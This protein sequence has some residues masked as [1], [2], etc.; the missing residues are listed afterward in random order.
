M[1]NCIQSYKLLSYPSL[2]YSDLLFQPIYFLDTKQVS[3]PPKSIV[4]PPS[5]KQLTGSL[6][7]SSGVNSRYTKELGNQESPEFDAYS[8]KLS[9]QVCR[10]L[11]V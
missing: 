2:L 9:V 4:A 11:L 10:L 3:S 6:R 5:T 7:V 1:V 8:T